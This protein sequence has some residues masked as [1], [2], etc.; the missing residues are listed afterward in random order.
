[1]GSDEK[2][3]TMALQ[4]GV[5]LFRFVEL[6]SLL[7]ATSQLSLSSSVVFVLVAVVVLYNNNLIRVA[8]PS[9]WNLS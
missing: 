1:M 2:R 4:E 9:N 6:I 7:V 8:F 5:H 3:V